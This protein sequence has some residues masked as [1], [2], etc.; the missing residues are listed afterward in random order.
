[1]NILKSLFEAK[2]VTSRVGHEPKLKNKKNGVEEWEDLRTH[3]LLPTATTDA[4]SGHK[5][6]VGISCLLQPLPHWCLLLV[7]LSRLGAPFNWCVFIWF[8]QVFKKMSSFKKKLHENDPVRLKE[9]GAGLKVPAPVPTSIFLYKLFPL[10]CVCK[11]RACRRGISTKVSSIELGCSIL[12]V[13]WLRHD[14]N[15]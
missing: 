1:M 8:F 14:S 7:M 13:T 9:T 6:L 3:N 12:A 4:H 5:I 10:D 2:D 11:K 15:I